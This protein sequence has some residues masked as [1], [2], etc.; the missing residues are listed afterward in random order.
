MTN[1]DV[2]QHR[3]PPATLR[4]SLLAMLVGT[5]AYVIIVA[6][7][8]VVR[9]IPAANRLQRESE[10]AQ[11]EF[12]ESQQR[13]TVLNDNLSTLKSMLAE[14]RTVD[15]APLER[16]RRELQT[17]EEQARTLERLALPTE[18]RRDL[19]P[20]LE[21]NI[22][23]EARLRTFLLGAIAAIEVDDPRSASQ[24]L[25]AADSVAVQALRGIAQAANLALRDIHLTEQDL[26][27]EAQSVSRTLFLV[28]FAGVLALPVLVLYVRRRFYAPLAT[29]AHGLD[30]V[31]S[32]NLDVHLPSPH[33][34]EL[35]R[36]A[37][38]FNEMTAVLRRQKSEDA[39]RSE[40]ETAARMRLMVAAALD[41]VVVMDAGGV[42]REWN[43]Q[44]EATFGW[45]RAEATGRPL[46]DLILPPDARE[47]LHRA[48]RDHVSAGESPMTGR[49]VRA[50][51]QRR[52][53]TLRS[54][55]LTITP[56]E[57][58]GIVEF[59][60]FIRDVTDSQRIE[61]ELRE[62]QKLDALGQLAGGVA[63]DFNNL[64]HGIIGGAELLRT[65][66]D[67]TPEVREDASLIVSIAQHGADLTR[68][69]LTVARRNH[70]GTDSVRID[71]VASEV[72]E[73]ISR[74][75]DRKVRIAADLNGGGLLIHGD[76]SQLS[77][78]LLNLALNA[79][80]AMPEGGTLR[81]A[82]SVV[83]P[84]DP[85]RQRHAALAGAGRFLQVV[86]QDTGAGI[87]PEVR[88]RIFEPFFTTKPEGSGTG[89]GLSM[90][91]GTVQ[92][93]RGAVDL[94]S[95]VGHGT[96][97]RLLLPVA[98]ETA[99]RDAANG[100]QPS[101]GR[102]R[103]LL[104]D[105]EPVVRNVAARMLR[106]L[107]YTVE[108]ASDGVEAVERVRDDP[109][110]FD[111]AILDGNMPRMSGPEAARAIKQ[112]QPGLTL[113]LATG[114]YRRTVEDRFASDGFASAL[115]KP[116]GMEALSHEVERLLALRRQSA[117]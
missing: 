108:V 7:I 60:A 54:I 49:L 81:I 26:A 46:G 62:A 98:E 13:A 45:T 31:S 64:L 83:A 1:P 89:L 74:T 102:G 96:T 71:E 38:H 3:T 33:D 95:E 99:T 59:S 10:G 55:E 36:L 6:S 105:D 72:V 69:L 68:R 107:G 88:T 21:A 87:A 78:A 103:I 17:M 35:G 28:F 65:N 8:V 16:M 37:Q 75:F 34:D 25:R 70:S 14:Q 109:L 82:T 4:R 44:A 5:L 18:T 110:P 85:V 19:R 106:S 41:A 101:R 57:R 116:F 12:S 112:L 24:V 114:T 84:D 97:F 23:R 61:Q 73:V 9:F 76:R 56:L 43:P 93:H 30:R 111:L 29:L 32:G 52:D 50:Q 53:G 48:L 100:R 27:Q 2:S 79:R 80:D 15:M 77:N 67:A 51:A 40:I 20:I 117:S 94:E 63:H 90:V 22:R 86:V 104:A 11:A 113:V 42:V 92:A 91:Y 39:E 115:A 58:Q 66:P 47:G